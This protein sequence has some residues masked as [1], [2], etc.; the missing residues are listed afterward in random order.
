MN[1]NNVLAV[2]FLKEFNVTITNKVGSNGEQKGFFLTFHTDG[3][4]QDSVEKEIVKF[5]NK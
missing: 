3:S 2:Q 5:E 1:S 4:I